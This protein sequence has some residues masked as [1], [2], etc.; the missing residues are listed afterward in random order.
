MFVGAPKCAGPP[1]PKKGERE[2]GCPLCGK[3]TPAIMTDQGLRW[4]HCDACWRRVRDGEEPDSAS[5][6]EETG[7]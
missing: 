2:I 4:S 7:G 5:V 1:N 3:Q 6:D